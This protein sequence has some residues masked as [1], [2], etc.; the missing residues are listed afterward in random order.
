MFPRFSRR[1][2][3]LGDGTGTG[4]I[5]P[6]FSV[7]FGAIRYHP[8]AF[9]WSWDPD[10]SRAIV[11]R[12]VSYDAPGI[13]RSGRRVRFRLRITDLGLSIV[14]DAR[15]HHIPKASSSRGSSV[16][17][18]IHNNDFSLHRSPRDCLVDRQDAGRVIPALSPLSSAF[19]PRSRAPRRAAVT[20]PTRP[21][22]G[23][24][25]SSPCPPLSVSPRSTHQGNKLNLVRSPTGSA[26]ST[27]TRRATSSRV[28]SARVAR[29]R[30]WEV[31]CVGS[32]CVG[33]GE[34][35]GRMEREGGRC[36]MAQSIERGI[37]SPMTTL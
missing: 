34:E 30:R 6:P 22:T 31:V 24:S 13:D 35:E 14:C 26:P 37:K 4:G 21:C 11:R 27:W 7:S 8:H 5:A 15:S 36:V 9:G 33:I 32:I 17:N 25:M 23:L 10:V 1:L 20:A 2:R 3:P 19:F 16:G 29:M 12:G 18:G 28:L